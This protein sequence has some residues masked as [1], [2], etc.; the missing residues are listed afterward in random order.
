MSDRQ[1]ALRCCLSSNIQ[2][3]GS[4]EHLGRKVLP[5]H[6]GK[7]LTHLQNAKGEDAKYGQVVVFEGNRG[8]KCVKYLWLEVEEWGNAESSGGCGN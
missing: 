2:K 7:G 5:G 8:T 4:R 6:V 3:P 1:I